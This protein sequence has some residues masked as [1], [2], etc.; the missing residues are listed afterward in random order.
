MPARTFV[1]F[2]RTLL[3]TPPLSIPLFHPYPP[4]ELN[5]YVAIAPLARMLQRDERR[6]DLPFFRLD[7]CDERCKEGY[8]AL[9]QNEMGSPLR[10]I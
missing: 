4:K 9:V 8:L 10:G 6:G 5:C 2:L 7:S 3:C 1:D